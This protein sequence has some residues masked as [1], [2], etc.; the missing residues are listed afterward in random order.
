M[1]AETSWLGNVYAQLT[2]GDGAGCVCK[3]KVVMMPILIG[4]A[5][6]Y[7]IGI[8][9]VYLSAAPRSAYESFSIVN[10]CLREIHY[11]INIRI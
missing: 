8:Q 3:W 5:G 1:E 10:I 9:L 11:P 4:L 6:F 7:D 2:T